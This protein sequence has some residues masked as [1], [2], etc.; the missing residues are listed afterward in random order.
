MSA[1]IFPVVWWH[2][3]CVIVTAKDIPMKRRS[4]QVL[5]T[6]S[7][8]NS[9]GKIINFIPRKATEDTRFGYEVPGMILLQ[10]YL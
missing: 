6:I 10:T 5:R 9:S 3:I 4:R 1:F 2:E 8:C 7:K